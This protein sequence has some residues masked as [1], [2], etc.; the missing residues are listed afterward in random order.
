MPNTERTQEVSTE[1]KLWIRL[2]RELT[3]VRLVISK[4]CPEALSNEAG[5]RELKREVWNLLQDARNLKTL[6]FLI[7]RSPGEES[8][9]DSE[10]QVQRL[11]PSQCQ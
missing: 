3:A 9:Q 8:I 1:N 11:P 7:T 10:K 5:L 6:A 2:T 4:T